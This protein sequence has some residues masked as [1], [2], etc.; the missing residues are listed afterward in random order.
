MGMFEG[1]I[2]LMGLVLIGLVLVALHSE[3]GPGKYEEE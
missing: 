1:L 2:V 3:H